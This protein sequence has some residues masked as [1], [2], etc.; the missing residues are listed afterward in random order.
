MH[1]VRIT[2]LAQADLH[3]IQERGLAAFGVVATRSFME[4]FDQIFA[5]LALYPL[6][7]QIRPEY[8]RGVRGCPHPPYRVLYRFEADVISIMAI[9]HASRRS[10]TVDDTKQ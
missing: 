9:V 8:G 3:D 5:N 1:R 7:G 4:G 10:H 6:L 2:R